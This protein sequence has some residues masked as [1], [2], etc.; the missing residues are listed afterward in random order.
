[1]GRYYTVNFMCDKETESII[2][3]IYQKP[4]HDCECG[5][6]WLWK[7]RSGRYVFAGWWNEVK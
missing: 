2:R 6:R 3:E 1:M 7:M 4:V 5:R